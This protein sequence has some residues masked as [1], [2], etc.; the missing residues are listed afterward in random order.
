MLCHPFLATQVDHLLR[1]LLYNYSIILR[2]G[3]W[4]FISIY[5]YNYTGALRRALRW[6]HGGLS[7]TL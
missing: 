1:E 6:R 5:S 3:E 2:D 4:G 7:V